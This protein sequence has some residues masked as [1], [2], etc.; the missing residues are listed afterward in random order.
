VVL[1]S[2]VALP[3]TAALAP[4]GPASRT[5]Q[6]PP[7]STTEAKPETSMSP[8]T[9]FHD[10]NVTATLTA[11]FPAAALGVG[12]ADTV[13]SDEGGGVEGIGAGVVPPCAGDVPRSG[14]PVAPAGVCVAGMGAGVPAGGDPVPLV[15]A[16]TPSVRTTN[17]VHA[18]KGTRDV[19]FCLR[20]TPEP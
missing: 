18:A 20:S 5:V 10:E 7:V 11:A 1:T 14:A 15:H 3:E 17:V 19:R 9:V 16:A 8:A 2:A 12:V 13:G 4:P 6:V